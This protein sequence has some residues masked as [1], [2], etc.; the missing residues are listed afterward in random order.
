MSLPELLLLDRDGVLFRHVDPYILSPADVTVS[1]GAPETVRAALE[2]GIPVAVV[3]NQSP[4]GRGLISWQ[5]VR[6]VNE[7]ITAWVPRCRRHRVRCYV[8]PHLPDDGCDCRK[9]LPGLLLR[10]ALDAGVDIGTAWMVGDHDTDIAAA[11]AAGCA[12]AVHVATGRQRAPSETADLCFD[13]LYTFVRLLND[14][15]ADD[16]A[17]NPRSRRNP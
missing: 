8:C 6:E 2:L 11:R 10:A 13:D 9:P 14:E 5:F 15:Q 4:I 17:N 3:T 12:V 7:R 16:T 1:P